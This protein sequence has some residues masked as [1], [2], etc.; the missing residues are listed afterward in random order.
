MILTINLQYLYEQDRYQ[1][2]PDADIKMVK[3]VS[4]GCL[5]FLLVITLPADKYFRIKEPQTHVLTHITEAKDMDNDAM[6]NLVTYWE[7]G[8]SFILDVKNI[9]NVCGQ[10]FTKGV[11]GKGKWAIIDHRHYCPC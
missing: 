5:H 6:M 7:Y 10:I 2:D 8:Q 11:V 3:T 9:K 4:Y 1:N